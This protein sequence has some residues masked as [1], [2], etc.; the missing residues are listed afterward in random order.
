V[1]KNELEGNV[2]W[3]LKVGNS[4]GPTKKKKIYIYIYIK[5][6]FFNCFNLLILK[7]KKIK[8]IFK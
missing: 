7:L 1:G 8:Y 3:V 2:S 5:M 4:Q 6:I